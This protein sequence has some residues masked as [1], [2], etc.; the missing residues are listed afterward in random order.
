MKRAGILIPTYNRIDLLVKLIQSI[1]KYTDSNIYEGL[2]L[3]NSYNKLKLPENF[4]LKNFKW[5]KMEN[6]LGNLACNYAIKWISDDCDYIIILNDDVEITGPNWVE[7]L[8]SCFEKEDKVG[9][10]GPQISK[11]M[12]SGNT[13]VPGGPAM[14]DEE[15]AFIESWCIM[16]PKQIFQCV[17]GFSKDDVKIVYENQRV[18]I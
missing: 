6:N 2:I 5:I 7:K 4:D 14:I 17:G 10:V 16:L 13:F 8:Y 1:Q 15:Y 12:V 3:D 9:I 11:V 18:W